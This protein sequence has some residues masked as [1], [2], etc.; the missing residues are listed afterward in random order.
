MYRVFPL[1]HLS[2]L[3][4]KH[5]MSISKCKNISNV[6]FQILK[7]KGGRMSQFGIHLASSSSLRP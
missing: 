6:E 2:N 5:L 4:P 1:I 3:F 7:L